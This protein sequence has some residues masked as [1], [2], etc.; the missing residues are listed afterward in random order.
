MKLHSAE[1]RF[2]HGLLCE[3]LVWISRALPSLQS[4]N[5]DTRK[6]TATN[7]KG[8]IW[9][10]GTTPNSKE[11]LREFGVRFWRPTNSKSRSESCSEHSVKGFSHSLG[12]ECNSESCSEDTP[13]FQELLRE[14]PLHSETVFFLQGREVYTTT[15]ETL[16]F[17]FFTLFPCFP[18]KIVYTI[19]FFAL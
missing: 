9:R 4:S 13:E 12:R 11:M 15:V 7:E 16:L 1:R 17:F 18:R 5:N 6:I 2:C 14:W 3:F 10:A 19:A 8:R